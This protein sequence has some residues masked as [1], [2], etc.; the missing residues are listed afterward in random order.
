MINKIIN[1]NKNLIIAV[2]VYSILYSYLIGSKIENKKLYNRNIKW[3][4]ILI[5]YIIHLMGVIGLFKI[6]NLKKNTIILNIVFFILICITGIASYHRLW[7]HRSYEANIFYKIFCLIFATCAHQRDAITWSRWHRTHHRCSDTDCDPHNNNEGLFFSHFAW[8][9]V[10]PNESYKKELQKTDVSDLYT[11]YLLFQKKYYTPLLIIF[12][13]VIPIL[14][15]SKWND[16]RNSFW[17]NW[18]RT[19]LVL[20]AIWCINSLTHTF[21]EKP[22][23][24]NIFPTENDFVT[25]I[26]FGEGHHNYH[27]TYPRDYR[28]SD[29]N[30]KYNPTAWFINL[31]SKFGLTY[32]KKYLKK[33]YNGNSKNYITIDGNEY[34][35]D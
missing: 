33:Y 35:I 17:M 11:P 7:T 24:N 21:G 15:A 2:L 9:L 8:L 30:F 10:H 32:N 29:T 12:A 19:I 23:N 13:H 16:A 31:C 14:I 20:H 26:T 6:K 4:R 18:I 5:F 1:K 3:S 28:A 27:H 34:V 25:L 22:F